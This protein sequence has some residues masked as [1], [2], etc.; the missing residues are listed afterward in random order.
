MSKEDE[1]FITLFIIF[2]ALILCLGCIGAFKDTDNTTLYDKGE[3]VC[4][5]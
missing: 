3:C 2:E 1:F 4:E 5:K